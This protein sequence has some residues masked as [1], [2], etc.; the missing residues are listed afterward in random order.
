MDGS[1]VAVLASTLFRN[2]AMDGSHVAVLASTLLRNSA[3]D[4]SHVAVLSFIQVKLLH[5]FIVV[6]CVFCAALRWATAGAR[7]QQTA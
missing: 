2:S 5:F 6:R 4:G 1:H 7:S 3:M